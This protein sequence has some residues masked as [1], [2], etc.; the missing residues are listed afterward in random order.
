MN[1]PLASSNVV[2][3]TPPSAGASDAEAALRITGAQSTDGTPSA[4]EIA[5]RGNS[6]P[7]IKL[8]ADGGVDVTL[9]AISASRPTT[10]TVVALP[11][12]TRPDAAPA[13]QPSDALAEAHTLLHGDLVIEG[14]IRGSDALTI[15]S[16][17]QGNVT[18][19]GS[20]MLQV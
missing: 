14:D 4:G 18:I 5:F 17:V 3:A 8:A 1:N 13:S 20:G 7:Q 16:V 15:Q 9:G 19:N 2:L 10:S 11:L 12:Q 6:T